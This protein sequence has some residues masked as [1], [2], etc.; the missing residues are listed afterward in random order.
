MER[1]ELQAQSRT[2]RGKQVRQLR[3]QG[4]IPAVLYGPD[5]PSR[6]I[7]V[8]EQ[9]LNKVLQ[10]AGGSALINLVVDKGRE[11]Y[12]VL[13]RGIQRNILTGHVQHVDFYQVR[14]YEK[15]R[16]TPALEIVGESP[17]ARTGMAIVN[18]AVS[19]LE[20]ECLPT[21]LIGSIHVDVSGLERMEDVIHVRDLPVPPGVTILADPDEVVVSLAPTRMALVTEAEEAEAVPSEA[22]EESRSV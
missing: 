15:I 19:Y 8:E 18:L 16:T 2:V 7:Q 20:V 13:T 3:N 6:A 10:Q 14:L 11:P 12:V 9:R 21:D 22:R 17:L 5:T 1:L 4:W